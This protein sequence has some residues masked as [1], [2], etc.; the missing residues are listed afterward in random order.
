MPRKKNNRKVVQKNKER[1]AAKLTPRQKRLAQRVERSPS[2]MSGL[3]MA[4]IAS[5]I[6]GS[7][8]PR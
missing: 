8:E 7:E 5:G 6:F 3:E 1:E 2:A 4:V